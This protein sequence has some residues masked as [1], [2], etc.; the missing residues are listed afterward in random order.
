MYAMGA[1]CALDCKKPMKKLLF[2][3]LAL[4]AANAGAQSVKVENAWIRGTVAQQKSTAAYMRLTAQRD[5]RLVVVT[6]PIAGIAE[7]HEMALDNGIM[8]MRAVTGLELPA[9]KA[10]ELKPGGYH[11]MLMDLKAAIAAEQRIALTLVFEARDGQ[12]EQV[13]IQVPARALNGALPGSMTQ[14]DSHG[15]SH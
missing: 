15:H 8:K 6:S 4:L 12:R 9:G 10:V 14:S 2:V 5:S 7:I 11:L 3:A 1:P 13:E